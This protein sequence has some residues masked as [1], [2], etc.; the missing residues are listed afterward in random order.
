LI[1][2]G[3]P[4][5]QQ[6]PIGLG[7]RL[8]DRD[9]ATIARQFE[10]HNEITTPSISASSGCGRCC[11]AG[12]MEHR[13]CASLSLAPH[14]NCRWARPGR[15]DRYYRAHD[16]RANEKLTRPTRHCRERDWS[17]RHHRCR[18]CRTRGTRRL[19]AL[20]RQQRLIRHGRCHLRTPVGLAQWFRA[21]CP[22]FNS[23]RFSH[24]ACLLVQALPLGSCRLCDFCSRLVIACWAPGRNEI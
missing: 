10:R 7:Q 3:R 24:S 23:W 20:H 1:T 14:H 6:V 13:Q 22:A 18:P 21:G 5:R 9:P 2:I 15:G 8:S 4:V 17:G 19:H 12:R 16:G 11:A